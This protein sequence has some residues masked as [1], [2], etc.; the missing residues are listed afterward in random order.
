M[1]T[2]TIELLVPDDADPSDVLQ[3]AHELS[4]VVWQGFFDNNPS[5]EDDLLPIIEASVVV[6]EEQEA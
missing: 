5:H 3:A 4:S 2:M 6:Y 1:K